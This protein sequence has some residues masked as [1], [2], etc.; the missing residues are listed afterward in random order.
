MYRAGLH[1]SPTKAREATAYRI[2]GMHYEQARPDRAGVLVKDGSI[3]ERL[4]WAS[5]ACECRVTKMVEVKLNI[6]ERIPSEEVC[7]H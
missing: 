1:V 6:S 5:R 3:V 4:L 2:T 7:K